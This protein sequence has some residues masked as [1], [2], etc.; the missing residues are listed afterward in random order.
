MASGSDNAAALLKEAKGAHPSTRWLIYQ[1]VARDFGEGFAETFRRQ[2][3]ESD[4]SRSQRTP[5]SRRGGR[6]S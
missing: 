4:R 3:E 1:R 5:R 2:V 6:S